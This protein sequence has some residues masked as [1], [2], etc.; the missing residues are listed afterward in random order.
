M[1]EKEPTTQVPPP[2]PYATRSRVT[3]IVHYTGRVLFF[4]EK[5]S[6]AKLKKSVCRLSELL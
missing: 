6:H 1:A 5:H 3:Q 4:D 2:N